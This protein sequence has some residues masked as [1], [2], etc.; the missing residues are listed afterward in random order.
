MEKSLP[1]LYR[2]V[3]ASDAKA[4]SFFTIEGHTSPIGMIVILYNDYKK[5]DTKYA[6]AIL[7]H[8]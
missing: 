5:Y 1:K 8:I 4:M 7:P 6:K 2:L 3:K